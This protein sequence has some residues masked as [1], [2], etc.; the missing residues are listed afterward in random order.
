M[1]GIADEIEKI[2]SPII[3]EGLAKSAIS[4]QCRKMGILPEDLSGDTIDELSERLREPLRLFAG[5]KIATDLVQQMKS[6]KK[7]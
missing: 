5:R 1:R 7:P 6:L 3:G 2:L 4:L